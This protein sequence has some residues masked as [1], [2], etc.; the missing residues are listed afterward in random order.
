MGER[1]L[2]EAFKTFFERT[3]SPHL[4]Q[5][6]EV[7]REWNHLNKIITSEPIDYSQIEFYLLLANKNNG[8][9]KGS[10]HT[11]GG[12][13]GKLPEDPSARFR[14]SDF[15][16]MRVGERA[17]QIEKKNSFLGNTGNKKYF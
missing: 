7:M 4:S 6:E 9:N 10:Q 3:V 12:S 15:N 16:M 17:G 2:V 13:F 11:I 8:Q 14:Q 1:K 5:N